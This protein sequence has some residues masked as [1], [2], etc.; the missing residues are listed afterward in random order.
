MGG[1]ER[2]LIW[3]EVPRVRSRTSCQ[4][5]WMGSSSMAVCL[6][7]SASLHFTET[8]ELQLVNLIL[9]IICSISE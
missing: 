3:V 1:E 8:V 4:R 2:W 9:I 6:N 7:P 5:F